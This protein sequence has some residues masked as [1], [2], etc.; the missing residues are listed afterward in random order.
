[1]QGGLVARPLY[2]EMFEVDWYVAIAGIHKLVHF[3][4]L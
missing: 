3:V 2:F 1:M 4:L